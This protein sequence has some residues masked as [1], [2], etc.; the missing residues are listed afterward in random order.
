M[1]SRAKEKKIKQLAR[2]L[3]YDSSFC[4][5]PR[6]LSGGLCILWKKYINVQ[7]YSWSSNYI[8][9]NICEKGGKSWFCNFVYGNPI[10]K[11]RRKLRKHLSEFK[12]ESA[13]SAISSDHSPLVLNLKNEM[14]VPTLFKYEAYWEEDEGCTKVV[15][16]A[17]RKNQATQGNWENLLDKL[18][19]SKQSL[20]KWSA[21]TLRRADKEIDKLQ[22]KIQKLQNS[23]IIKENQKQIQEAKNSLGRL[24]K[25]EEKY[26]AKEQELSG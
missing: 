23:P 17:W 9:T 14:R 11:D 6:G 5:E 15:E 12:S 13:L 2:R 20:T 19:N 26:W 7:V 1:E 16:E 21:E 24:W 10:H 22:W 4:V 3:K 18:K 8:K 25:Q